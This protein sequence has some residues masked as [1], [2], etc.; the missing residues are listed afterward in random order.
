M[1]AAFLW[2][3]GF[4]AVDSWLASGAGF[5]LF[6]SSSKKQIS[7]KYKQERFNQVISLSSARSV[8]VRGGQMTAINVQM[9]RLV[10][11]VSAMTLFC[12]ACQTAQ[13]IP[14]DE[15]RAGKPIVIAPAASGA[16]ANQNC[17]NGTYI[18]RYQISSGVHAGDV[19]LCCIPIN[20]LLRD[21]FRCGGSLLPVHLGSSADQKV[22]TCSL[23]NPISTQVEYIPACIPAPLK[24]PG[25]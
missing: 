16:Q 6:A 14:L 21:S 2:P 5:Q 19:W 18:Y 24:A 12:S 13:R 23:L 1:E 10:L 22:Q 9:L 8:G 25:T 11:A 7:L 20:E 3:I 17:L 4:R 15:F